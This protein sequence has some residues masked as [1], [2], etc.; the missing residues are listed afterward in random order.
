MRIERLDV[1]SF[2]IPF[3]LTFRHASASRASAANVIV[4]VRSDCG[5]VGYGEGCPRDYVTGETGASATQF[6]ARHNDSIIRCVTSLDKLRQWI[7]NHRSE[8]DIDPAAFCA[9]ELAILDLLGKIQGQS[10]EALVGLSPLGG[11]FRYSAVLGDNGRL[12]FW[13]QFRRY[14]M[15]GF[16]DFKVKVSGDI[17]RDRRKLALIRKRADHDIRLR[18][19]ANNLWNSIDDCVSFLRELSFPL[20]AVEEPLTAGHMAGFRAVAQACDTRVVLDESF[21]RPTQL[22]ELGAP[23]PWIINMR[24]SKMGG[25]LRSMALAEEAMRRGIGII[26][27]AHVGETSIL[28]RV[29][30]TLAHALGGGLTAMEGAYGTHLL[31]RDLTTP[32]LMFGYGGELEPASVLH[33]DAAGLG[34]NVNT[35]DL[36]PDSPERS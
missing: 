3:K 8:I 22:D 29:G 14:W 24:V 5:A 16:R 10:V 7:S 28:T 21:L 15:S 6:I 11:S 35:R 31:E 34:L 20:F 19:D 30:L 25:L 4:T 17:N 13:L 27:G 12:V 32:C 9:V 36:I 26:V 33:A 18:L 23:E 2:P 1:S